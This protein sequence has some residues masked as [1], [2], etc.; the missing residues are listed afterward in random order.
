MRRESKNSWDTTDSSKEEYVITSTTLERPFRIEDDSYGGCWGCGGTYGKD[1]LEKL[2]NDIAGWRKNL[3]EAPYCKEKADGTALRDIKAENI[4]V[5]IDD[6]AKDF[7]NRVA[8]WNVNDLIAE[9]KAIKEASL[10]DE[11]LKKFER[12]KFLDKEIN[13]IRYDNLPKLKD[14]GLSVFDDKKD[15]QTVIDGEK[16]DLNSV[17]RLYERL[18][19]KL[20]QMEKEHD[21]LKH[22]MYRW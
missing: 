12:M 18:R 4:R 6:R 19:S 13:K 1:G 15:A 11:I 3:L 20:S 8:N 10:T 5:F 2:K 16:F 22:E 14:K 21:E 17:Y 7:I 9:L